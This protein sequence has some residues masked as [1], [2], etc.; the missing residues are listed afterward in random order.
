MSDLLN[1]ANLI[2]LAVIVVGMF[3]GLRRI[4]ASTHGKSCCSDGASG[5][6]AKKVVVTDT[7]P[8]HYPYSD[9]LLIGG[10]SCDGCVQN[11]ENALNALDGV[12]ATVTYADHTARVRSKRPVDRDTLETAVRGAGYYVMKM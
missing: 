5:K 7:D 9:E 3:F 8:S 12:W 4:V 6:K 10:M 11:V 2:V 1:P